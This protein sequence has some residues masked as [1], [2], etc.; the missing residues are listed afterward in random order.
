MSDLE[1]ILSKLDRVK[2]CAKGYIAGCPAHE[3]KMPSLS[4]STGKDGRVLL[5]CHAGCQT[6]DILSALGLEPKDL[7]LD[8]ENKPKNEPLTTYDYRDANGKLLYQVCR[9]PNK[10]FVQR[11]SDGRGGWLYNLNGVQRVP[12]SLPAV[13]EAINAGEIIYIVEGEKD[14]DRLAALG[15]TTTT[16][17]GGA[18]KWTDNLSAHFKDANVVILP[19]NDKPGKDHAKVVAQS[20]DGVAAS[21]KIPELAGLPEKGDVSDWLSA[22]NTAEDLKGVLCTTPIYTPCTQT[23]QNSKISLRP[24]SEV[25]L[26]SV[27]ERE[28]L[29]D[30]IMPKIGLALLVGWSKEGKSTLAI[31]LCRAV[32]EGLPFLGRDTQKMPAVYVNYEMPE[33]Y[34]AEL[35]AAANIPEGA[36]WLDRPEHVLSCETIRRIINETGSDCGLL[37]IDSFRGAFRPTG[38]AENSVGGAGVV[39]RD[40]QKLAAETGWLILLIHHKNRS[41]KFS[42][43]GD[44]HAAADVILSWKR[45]NPAEP[46]SLEVEGRMA[47]VEPLAVKLTLQGAEFLGDAKEILAAEDMKRVLEV[48]TEE[49]IEAAK[50]GEVL[51]MRTGSARSYLSRLYQ[52]G[53]IGRNGNGKRGDPYTYFVTTEQ[54]QPATGGESVESVQT[55][56]TGVVHN[57]QKLSFDECKQMIIDEFD[58]TEIPGGAPF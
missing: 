9:F 27:E 57:T 55:V 2:K 5:H 53:K 22:E 46:G 13:I 10:R 32:A 30:G 26:D 49:P 8:N 12:Y 35:I 45:S 14:A 11:R 34:R 16:N 18:G 21:V 28:W 3:D 33:D 54:R 7:F 36:F 23:T 15:L 1:L 56:K 44:F 39:C 37:V 42:G 41:G 51:E 38:D 43:T 29:L 47:P 20:L 48:L 4:V 25:L 31:H 40:L 19:D 52:D 6:S 58:A 17:S 24:W 50:I